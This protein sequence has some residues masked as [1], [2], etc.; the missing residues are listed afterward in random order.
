MLLCWYQMTPDQHKQD[1]HTCTGLRKPWLPDGGEQLRPLWSHLALWRGP[2]G[3]QQ[4]Q[5][6]W[7]GGSGY[8]GEPEH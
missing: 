2:V 7:P 6:P 5:V 8:E 4:S 1:A 3:L